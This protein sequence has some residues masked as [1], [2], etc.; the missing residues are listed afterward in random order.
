[1]KL[2]I[3]E[4]FVEDDNEVLGLA[5]VDNPAIQ[6]NYIYF[7]EEEIKM[8]FNDEQMIV[9][10]AALIP[11]KLI[12]RNDSLG[13]RYVYFSK[14]TIRRFAELLMNKQ[15]EKFNLGHTDNY[16][17]ANVVESYFA[18]EPNEFNVPEGS[19]I[20]SL[21]VLDSIAWNKIKNGEY[22]GFSVQGL[23]ANEIVQFMKNKNKKEETMDLK[24]KLLNAIN[25]V[26]FGE[27]TPVVE[28]P[29]EIPVET[30][31]VETPLI[32]E[33]VVPQINYG[34]K[35]AELEAV[36]QL[37]N[38]KLTQLD[39]NY[40]EVKK[41]VDEYSKQPIS[42]SVIAEEV[43]SATPIKGISKATKYFQK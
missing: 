5:L 2:P 4:L 30:P 32:Q 7:N 34:E 29:V 14:E 27:E 43:A 23:F 41:L 1:M 26:L 40:I 10:G 9:K 36:I 39:N 35:Y 13:E 15:K 12:Y 37:L 16:L 3:F 31:V 17:K 19:W 21:H 6:E 28:A 33:V 42:Q 11:D 22:N 25:S 8:D 38:E 24:E 18:T 20:V